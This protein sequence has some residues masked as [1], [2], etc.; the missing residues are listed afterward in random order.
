MSIKI[1]IIGLG[2]VGLPLAHAFSEKYDV[3]GFDIHKKRINELC[4]AYDNTLELSEKQLREALSNKIQFTTNIENI[5]DS[6]IYI[7]TVPTPIDKNK[8]PDLT[9]LFKAS[10][11][12]GKVLKKDDIVV[13][14]LHDSGSRYVGKF[15]NDD[16]MKKNGFKL[17]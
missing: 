2:Y 5:K 1:C 3:V 14:L 13:V 15:Y 11:T 8:K 7:V 16:W 10:E 4:L 17:D 9:P 6:N 12:I